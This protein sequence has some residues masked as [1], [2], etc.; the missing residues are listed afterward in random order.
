MSKLTVDLIQSRLLEADEMK[1]VTAQKLKV[2]KARKPHEVG[3]IKDLSTN[4]TKI[5]QVEV[6]KC[7]GKATSKDSGSVIPQSDFAFTYTEKMPT[8]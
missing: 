3:N 6:P 1:K 7:E 5:K 2:E 8:G 4:L